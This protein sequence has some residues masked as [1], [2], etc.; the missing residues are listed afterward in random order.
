MK[1]LL[2][3]L[4]LFF[5]FNCYCQKESTPPQNPSL[6]FTENKGQWENNILFK[7]QLDGGA[8]FL[9][10]KCLTFNFYDKVKYRELHHATK[11]SSSIGDNQIKSHAFKIHFENCNLIN[12]IEKSLVGSDYE[13]FFLGNDKNKWQGNVFNY[14]RIMYKNIYDGIDYEALTEKGTLKYNFYVKPNSAA[15]AIKLKY[16]GANN[17]RLKEGNL[18]YDIGI[19][20]IIEQKPYAYQFINGRKLEINC[21]YILKNNILSFDFPYGYDK[22]FE[23]VIDPVLIFA[24]QSGSTSDNFGMC[25]TW[26]SEGNFYSGGTAFNIGYPTTIGAY[27]ITFNGPPAFGLTDIVITKYNT[28]GNALLFS[29][30]IGGADAEIVT[31]LIVDHSNNLCFSG[32]TGSNNFPITVGAYDNT[33]NGGLLLSFLTNGTA[34]NNGTDI[35]VGKLNSNGTSLLAST[36]L[37][38]SDNDGVNHVN[39]LSVFTGTVLEYAADSLHFNYGDQYRGEIQIDAI[40]N[41]YIASSTRSSNFPTT[42]NAFDNSLGGKQDAILAKFN[43][44]LSQL[45]YSTYI[46]GSSNDC[47]NSL[48]VGN[49][50]VYITGGTCSNNFPTTPGVYDPTY[51]GGK[52][53]GYIS[54]INTNSGVLMESTF[55][56]TS[57][58]DQSYFI[59]SDAS[60][61]IYVY[62]Q[63][64]GNMPIIVAGY[65]NP[66]THQFISRYNSNL[67]GLNLSTVIGSNTSNNDIS[68][69]AFSVDK[70]G[71]I[72]LSGWGGNFLGGI[73]MSS[74]PLLAAT[75]A[76]TDGFD[77]YL[78][79]LGPNAS[80][81]IYGSYFG[82][83]LSSEHVDG[84]TS[85]IDKN[86]KYYQSVCGGCGGNDDFPVTPGAWPNTIGDPNHSTNCNNGIFKIDL[87]P[88]II[89]SNI[90]LSSS[91]GCLPFTS[92]LT[93]VSPGT[94]YL[95]YLP[96]I[97]T[98]STIANPVIT[99]T[100][101]GTY[102][103]SL[104]VY[105]AA[106]CNLKDSSSIYI[107]VNPGV[108]PTINVT[109][110]SLICIGQSATLSASGAAN[111]VWSNGSTNA[112][113][114]VNPSVTTTYTI[115]GTTGGCSANTIFTQ[116]VTT[117]V[118]INEH[119]KN[120]NVV[121]I[122][123]NPNN[124]ICNISSSEVIENVTITDI[125]GKLVYLNK[126]VNG[127][128]LALDILQ[129]SKGLYFI[130]VKTNSGNYNFKLIKD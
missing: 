56:G 24:A 32:A 71:N 114:I 130:S 14:Q 75:Q 92:S 13:N 2:P 22:N 48:I 113:A 116:S 94:S 64:L 15:T 93:N 87:Q 55:L 34:F 67:S 7:A 46:G 12:E 112:T 10:K 9:E 77:F 88:N 126:N 115:T 85:R 49:Q 41:I 124:G 99:F 52:A 109:G 66:G 119:L 28:T 83:S 69:S 42:A 18:A 78:M 84:G 19:T 63:S 74:M 104:V 50:D 44:S 128:N 23:L 47:G 38:G 35:Y 79:G 117:C 68:P 82:G 54:H 125:T 103:V 1:K 81:L 26:D 101:T 31:S 89:S 100:N 80:S 39:H 17:M 118:T 102:T 105:N 111:Y 65:S 106:A 97:G 29:T 53:D 33:F 16:E 76:T 58:Y 96:N 20:E 43:P 21:N 110:P 127:N 61:N 129:S 73:P 11:N 120:K 62:G 98:S 37:G 36:F 27:S 25:A 5:G 121:N 70:C 123:P 108:T 3:I 95:W 59:Q 60:N 8:L 91:S 72:Y 107:T 51:N 4:T 122:Y 6:R 40:D 86:G 90:G 57:N 30:Y 45:L